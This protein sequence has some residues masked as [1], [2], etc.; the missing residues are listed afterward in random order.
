MVYSSKMPMPPCTP[1]KKKSIP[2]F[3][4]IPSYTLIKH[5]DEGSYYNTYL[6]DRGTVIRIAKR[7]ASASTEY[8]I[9]RIVDSNDC[10]NRI[11]DYWVDNGYAHFEME[12]CSGDNLEYILSHRAKDPTF[13]KRL[14]SFLP[15]NTAYNAVRNHSPIHETNI[16]TVSSAPEDDIFLTNSPGSFIYTDDESQNSE[17]SRSQHHVVV[18][19]P[20]AV[21]LMAR[22]ASALDTLHHANII[23][24]DIKPANI[25]LG[26]RGF[27]LCDFNISKF[28]EGTFDLDGDSLYMAPEI[29]KNKAF[30]SSD[31]YS[32]GI[33]YLE[34]CNP[35][36]SL[37]R[38]GES[39]KNLRSN[40]FDGWLIDKIGIKMLNKNPTKR[41]TA[42]E[43][44]K[45]FEAYT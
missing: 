17:L 11:L 9:L 14:N 3:G 34:L 36:K 24:M 33:I 25:L 15:I 40:N 12:Y 26:E 2:N 44:R 27:V 6:T 21:T 13:D 10:I 1:A 32:L 23:H 30:F 7:T 35:G 39:Y 41:C 43:I 31:I 8:K 42:N 22:I 16:S 5:I 19:P 4:N 45:H 37:P 29:L 28:G 38:D 18:L 20:W